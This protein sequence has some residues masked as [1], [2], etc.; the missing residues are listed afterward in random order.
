ME[1]A[2]TIIM[3]IFAFSFAGVIKRMGIL[4]IIMHAALDKVK[5]IGVLVALTSITT[6]I[7]VSFTGS[8]NVSSLLNGSI[9]KEEYRRKKIHPEVLARTMSMNGALWNA[10]LPWSASG[11]LC[12]SVLGVN[13]FEYT[14]YMIPFWFSFFLNIIFAFTGKFIRR[15]PDEE[16]EKE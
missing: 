8:A 6:L 16:L 10:M 12:L 11:A 13:N 15:L 1:F 9:Y 14:F 5:S 2:G 3:L 4:E 7:G